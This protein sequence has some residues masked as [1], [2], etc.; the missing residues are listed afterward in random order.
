ML[1]LLFILLVLAAAVA[2]LL[3]AGT[4][5]IQGYVY[6]EATDG[7]EWR[8]PAAGGVIGLFFA[9][10]CILEANA[11]GRFDSLVN[12]SP[13]DTTSFD[14]FVSERVNERGTQEVPYRRARDD[15][16]RVIYVD[17]DGRPWRRSDNGMMTAIIVEEDGVR[18]RF[19][20]ERNP[21]GTFH[22]EPNQP[23][24]YVEQGGARRVMTDNALGEVSVTRYGLLLGNLALNLLHL[25][26]WFA[27]FWLLLRF[28]WS[29]AL[30]LA[31]IFWLVFAV[32]VWPVLQQ[33]VK[34][35]TATPAAVAAM[36]VRDRAVS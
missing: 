23:L 7:L 4:A 35:A 8:A 31:V 16:G 36:G 22:V 19:E 34:R 9:V 25:L 15:R 12:F 13:R 17:P 14:R 11:P 3:A 33:R 18:T 21:G 26:A 32:L 1:G 20:A 27:C 6:E 28:Q 24:R 30:G 5:I 2:V 10:W 29:H